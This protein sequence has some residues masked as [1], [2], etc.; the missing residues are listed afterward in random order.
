[1]IFP[2]AALAAFR[3]LAASQSSGIP[4]RSESTGGVPLAIVPYPLSERP[5]LVWLEYNPPPGPAVPAPVP[6]G[7]LPR[8]FTWLITS[9]SISSR[10]NTPASQL[11][12][13]TACAAERGG[14]AEASRS[15]VT[16]DQGAAS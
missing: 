3:P 15:V 2:S 8:V 5:V 13:T 1:M 11:L 6:V 9:S 12:R 4:S 16:L 14:F 10:G 7:P